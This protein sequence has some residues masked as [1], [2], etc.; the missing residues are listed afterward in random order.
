MHL[1]DNWSLHSPCDQW[2]ELQFYIFAVLI[3]NVVE[4]LGTRYT[5]GV[6]MWSSGCILGELMS[7]KPLFPGTTTFC[8]L[9][10]CTRI[11]ISWSVDYFISLGTSTMNQIEKVL[12]I[13][14]KPKPV[15][16]YNFVIWFKYLLLMCIYKDT[17][18]LIRILY[19]MI[20]WRKI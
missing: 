12:E 17:M 10:E 4:A 8:C 14:G 5:F 3:E 11:R 15:C 7:G 9:L 13:I 19:N 20:I 16:S 18:V 2:S 6:D 1:Y